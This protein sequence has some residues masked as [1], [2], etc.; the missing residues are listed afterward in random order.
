[1]Y[2]S[3]DILMR[4]TTCEV[5]AEAAVLH[6][7]VADGDIATVPYNV[8]KPNPPSKKKLACQQNAELK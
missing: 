5:P 3:A 6:L 2:A 1:M 4:L 7:V 8:D